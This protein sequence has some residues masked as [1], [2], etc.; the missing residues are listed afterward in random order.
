LIELLKNN[1]DKINWGSL[2]NNQ[3]AIE[4]LKEKINN[5]NKN[6]DD[7]IDWIILSSNKNAIELIKLIELL[8]NNKD[9]INWGSL[10]K[11]SSIFINE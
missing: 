10:S 9:K 6:N 4:L 3:A 8:K 5:N 11:N 2:S 7:E 1:K